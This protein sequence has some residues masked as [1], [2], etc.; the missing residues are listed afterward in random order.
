M[1][2]EEVVEV[3]KCP[4]CGNKLALKFINQS[5]CF[6]CLKYPACRHT[7]WLPGSVI[8]KATATNKSCVKCGPD[9][10]CVQFTLRSFRHSTVLDQRLIGEDGLTYETCL[11]CDASFQDLCDVNRAMLS[12][13]AVQDTST[14]RVAPTGQRN[15]TSTIPPNSNRMPSNNFQE[16]S[17]NRP[18]APQAP[19]VRPTAPPPPSSR[20]SPHPPS[21]SGRTTNNND[22][23][24]VKCNKCSQVARK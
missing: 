1:A 8:K 9:F 19:R 24:E 6:S 14:R 21:T 18:S 11:M 12:P 10:K 15:N 7:I 3:C 2:Y 20:P 13:N 16:P 22:T 4:K 23:I 17:R 5:Y